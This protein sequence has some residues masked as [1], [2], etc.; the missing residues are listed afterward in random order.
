MLIDFMMILCCSTP[1]EPYDA[2]RHLTTSSDNTRN[3]CASFN[4]RGTA[5]EVALSRAVTQNQL[6]MTSC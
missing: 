1:K 2:L 4:L 5:A 6:C 3:H